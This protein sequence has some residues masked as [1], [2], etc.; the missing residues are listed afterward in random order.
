M[1]IFLRPW[2][3]PQTVLTFSR[4]DVQ[5][6]SDFLKVKKAWFLPLPPVAAGPYPHLHI[7]TKA[8]TLLW[9]R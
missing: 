6:K 4:T 2:M 9:A 7:L 8:R 5:S 1:A 3:P